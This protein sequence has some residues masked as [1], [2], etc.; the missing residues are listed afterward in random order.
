[1]AA[2]LSAQDA[3]DIAAYF[4]SQKRVVGA[5]ANMELATKGQVV[6]QGGVAAKG[7]AACMSCHGPSGAGNGPANFPSL[8]GQQS[9]YVAK[10]LRD[11]KSGARVTDPNRMMR[12]LAAKM[13]DEEIDAVAEYISGLH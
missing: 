6:Y 4:A 7:V 8:Q 10:A 9:M 1:M 11:F 5:P 3:A 13:S 12:D 2:P